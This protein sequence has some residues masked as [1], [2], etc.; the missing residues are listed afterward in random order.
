MIT[1][2]NSTDTKARLIAHYKKLKEIKRIDKANEDWRRATP[3]I[4][5]GSTFYKDLF[6][7]RSKV[8][9]AEEQDF[10]DM[11]LQPGLNQTL[12][13]SVYRQQNNMESEDLL[14]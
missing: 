5:K 8:G 9:T 14:N 7:L 10:L 6:D 4:S 1:Q 2:S 3:V 13:E 12:L 11:T